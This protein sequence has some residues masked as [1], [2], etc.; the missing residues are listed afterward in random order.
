MMRGIG[1]CWPAAERTEESE[2]QHLR[3]GENLKLFECH[4]IADPIKQKIE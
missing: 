3:S 1:N 4:L 2:S